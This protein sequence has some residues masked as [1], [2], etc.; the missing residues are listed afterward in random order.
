MLFLD[1]DPVLCAKYTPYS[2]IPEIVRDI[3][4]GYRL[5]EKMLLAQEIYNDLPRSIAAMMSFSNKSFQWVDRFYNSLFSTLMSGE[6]KQ[7][8]SSSIV[9]QKLYEYKP[10]M[11]FDPMWLVDYLP[12][13]TKSKRYEE[14]GDIILK[15]RWI[16]SELDPS[17]DEFK[18]GVPEWY[19]NGKSGE[20]V[21]ENYDEVTHTHIKI[22]NDFDRYRYYTAYKT[23]NWVEVKNVPTEMSKIVRYL[24]TH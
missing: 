20:V 2:L 12:I 9:K 24:I 21:L 1:S 10:L 17:D 5:A 15:S 14:C 18:E 11:F 6:P 23:D 4:S 3:E 22:E 8:S 13:T 16:L 19:L 7:L